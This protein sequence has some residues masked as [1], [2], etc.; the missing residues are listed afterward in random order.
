MARNLFIGAVVVVALIGI[1]WVFT[2]NG[3]MGAENRV[4]AEWSNVEASYQRRADLIQNLVNT[5]KGA[6]EYERGTLTEVVEARANA[7]SIQLNA[8]ELTPENIQRFQSAQQEL[9]GALSRLL[10]TVERYPE[11]KAVEGFTQLQSQ[12]EGTE[13]RINKARY[14]YNEAVLKYNNKITKIPGSLLAGSM[15]KSI[16]AGF[17][18]DA[19]AEVAPTVEF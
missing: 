12:L 17:E 4:N 6:A 1:I 18:A 16:K 5:V 3:I 2:Y 7:T 14:N 11:L 9:S 10:V 8:D 13:N 19:G 15:G